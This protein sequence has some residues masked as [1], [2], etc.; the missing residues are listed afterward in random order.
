MTMIE[1]R[2]AKLRERLRLRGIP[3]DQVEVRGC[4]TTNGYDPD[5]VLAR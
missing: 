2:P 4:L 5:V 3:N 1:A